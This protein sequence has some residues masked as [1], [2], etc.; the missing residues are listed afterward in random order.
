MKESTVENRYRLAVKAK[1]GLCIKLVGVS[2][3]GLPDRI[4]LLPGGRIWFCEFKYGRGTLSARQVIVGDMLRRL[5]FEV[6][7]INEVNVAEEIEKI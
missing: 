5:G 1:G 7:V 3:T 2:F 6:K 4:N